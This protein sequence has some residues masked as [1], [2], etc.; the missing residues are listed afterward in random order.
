[1]LEGQEMTKKKKKRNGSLC[2]DGEEAGQYLRARQSENAR[3]KVTLLCVI[4]GH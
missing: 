2:V 3:P 4:S 1:M